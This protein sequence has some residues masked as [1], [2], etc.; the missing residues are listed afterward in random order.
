MRLIQGSLVLPLLGS[1]S[2]IRYVAKPIDDPQQRRPDISRAWEMLKWKPKVR[3]AFCGVLGE[4]RN[5]A[6]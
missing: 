1:N 3:A 2:E 4:G 5:T 6:C